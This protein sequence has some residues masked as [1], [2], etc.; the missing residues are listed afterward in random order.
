MNRINELFGT[1]RNNILSVYFTAGY[2][3][4][5]SAIKILEYLQEAGADMAEIGIPFSDPLADGPIIQ[6]S[7]S[8]ALGNGMSLDK[9]FSQMAGIRSTVSIPLVLM[10]YLNPVLKYGVER[11]CTSCAECGIDGVIIPDLPPE[12]FQNGFREIFEKE[13]IF[14]I[15][16]ISPETSEERIRFIDSLSQG[17]IYMVSSSS[18]TGKNLG[19]GQSQKAYFER[20]RDMRTRNP[21]LTGF[22]ISSQAD[23]ATACS[24]SNGAITGSAF[25]RRISEKGLSRDVVRSFVAE[26]RGV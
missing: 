18:T 12:T 22:G 17:F 11:F 3:E 23:F 1:G 20:V 4:A 8:I 9:L 14:K 16:L 19:Y 15:F 7:N 25:I 24:Y 13:G 5:G 10:G 26:L 6:K 21:V 2:P